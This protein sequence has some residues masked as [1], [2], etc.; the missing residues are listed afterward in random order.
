MSLNDV[1]L[2]DG[3][4]KL[5][6]SELMLLLPMWLSSELSSSPDD[7]PRVNMA[8]FFLGGSGLFRCSDLYC[9]DDFSIGTGGAAS[10]VCDR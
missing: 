8:P 7:P 5:L 10:C 6:D 4:C 2:A 9:G 1:C 3:L